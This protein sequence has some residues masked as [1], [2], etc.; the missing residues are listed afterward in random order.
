MDS[1]TS[2]YYLVIF[3][4]RFLSSIIFGFNFIKLRKANY[5]LLT[6]GLLLWSISPLL[7]YL[8]TQ[9][10]TME[11]INGSS[12]V[13][14]IYLT[15]LGI[16]Q[17]YY[18]KYTKLQVGIGIVYTAIIIVLQ[19][20]T[21]FNVFLLIVASQFFI[22]LGTTIFLLL[23]I[24]KAYKIGGDSTYFL[25][26]FLASGIVQT[27][28]F[29]FFPAYPDSQFARLMQLLVVV[30]I[31]LFIFKIEEHLAYKLLNETKER[32]MEYL[33]VLQQLNR[34]EMLNSYVGGISHNFNNILAIIQNSADL[35]LEEIE[36]DEVSTKLLDQILNATKRG[37]VLIDRLISKTKINTLKK[38]Q[39]NAYL[40][41]IVDFYQTIIE[42][43]IRIQTAYYGRYHIEIDPSHLE[44]VM[45]NLINNARDSLLLTSKTNKIIQ[46]KT[47]DITDLS[48]NAGN[49]NLQKQYL[50]ISVRDNGLG[51]KQ[52]VKEKIFE[53]F[54]TTKT[55]G[56]GIGLATI[57]TLITNYNGI[58]NVE[59]DDNVTEFA[60]YLPAI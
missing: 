30:F 25:I 26:L 39:V 48:K 33:K 47:E 29:I 32:E 53:P 5:Y 14:G 37:S 4:L 35:V 6:I 41:E 40:D 36:L 18:N 31:L 11:I 54:F 50:K 22:V 7:Y 15:L 13:I 60:I 24:K 59:S 1:Y 43:N 57:K 34:T 28:G 44:E 17:Y 8:D 49:R 42:K 3:T 52:E 21:M 51:I 23:Q 16:V 38:I 55:N 12:A 58:I 56:Y 46:I 27:L 19:I 2:Y 9:S 20:F 10:R 45:I